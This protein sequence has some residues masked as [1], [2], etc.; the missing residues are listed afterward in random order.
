[1]KVFYETPVPRAPL[2]FGVQKPS[3]A[4]ASGIDAAP[5]GPIESVSHAEA[6]PPAHSHD[7]WLAG[8]Y[9]PGHGDLANRT[10]DAAEA[11]RNFKR[12]F[13]MH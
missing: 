4:K 8:I 7:Q 9:N 1:M 13:L 11:V 12:S 6:A 2:S 5:P 3:E 10:Y